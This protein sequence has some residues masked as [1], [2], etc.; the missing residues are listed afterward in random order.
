MRVLDLFA[1][2]GGWSAAA[3]DR[4]HEVVSIDL[5]PSFS[6]TLVAD[7]LSL[8]ASTLGDFDLVLASPPCEA[9]SVAALGHHWAPGYVPDTDHARLSIDLVRATVE[10]L[11]RL[12]PTAW[13]LENPRGMLRKLDLVPAPRVTVWYCRYGDLAAKP[14]DLWLGGAARSFYFEPECSNGGLDHN[15]APRGT[16]V[17]GTQGRAGAAVRAEVPYGLSLSVCLQ[18]EAALDGS[19]VPGRLV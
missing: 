15:R 6:P 5:D 13:V 14:T 16:R 12:D 17:G 2:R 10:I 1:G 8:D 19:L 11:D 9:F 3:R 7:V 4:G 18:T